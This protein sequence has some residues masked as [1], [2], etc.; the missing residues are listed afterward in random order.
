L[1]EVFFPISIPYS[2]IHSIL[3]AKYEVPGP[4]P[5]IPSLHWLLCCRLPISVEQREAGWLSGGVSSEWG[6]D[7]FKSD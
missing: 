4:V 6:R 5:D 3:P 2:I 7:H 1:I